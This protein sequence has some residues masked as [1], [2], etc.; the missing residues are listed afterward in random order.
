MTKSHVFVF[1][2]SALVIALV[3]R[4]SSSPQDCTQTSTC[5]QEGGDG[6]PPLVCDTS[7]D[8]KDDPGCLD[9]R[10]GVFVS[11]A[12]SDSNAGTKEAPFQTIGK[13]LASVGTLTRVYLCEGTYAEDVSIAPPVDGVSIYGGFKCADWSYSGNKPTIGKGNIALKISGTTKPFA[14][15]DV[16][17]QAAAGNSSNSSSIAALV[18][19]A[20]GSIAFTRVNLTA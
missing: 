16:L 2:G 17:V 1:F 6:P 18:A 10:V 11:P 9:D 13:A 19:N 20:T 12:G 4:C 14:I 8:P 7:K 5:P 15:E 3:P